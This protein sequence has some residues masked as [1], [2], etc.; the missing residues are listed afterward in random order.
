MSDGCGHAG[1]FAPSG[2]N[3]AS[4]W[5]LV[6][7]QVQ[8]AFND[9]VAKFVL[10]PFGA[11]L[12]AHGAGFRGIEHL[13]AALLVLPFILFAPS[14]GWLADRFAKHAVIR[15]AAWLQ[16]AVL[17][18]MALALWQRQLW[19]AI[20][21][22]FLLALQ[23]AVLS[24][25]KMG[26]VK[27]LLGS[28]RLA[29][30]SGVMEAT[31]ILAILAGQILGG[32]WFDLGLRRGAG[33]GLAD[34]WDAALLTVLGLWAG[35]VLAILLAHAVERTRPQGGGAFS[36][37]LAVAH[38]RDARMVWRDGQLRTSV[39]GVAYFWGFAGFVNLVVLQVAK[40]LHGGGQG[41]GTAV[42]VMMTWASA[43]I[44]AGSVLA[45]LKSR[46]GLDWGL[47]P[48]GAFVMAGGLFV[49]AGVP[50]GSP[51]R[52]W[53]LAVAGA[54]AAVF[55][56]PLNAHVQDHPPAVVR[57]AV[58]A[59]TNLF[60]NL[61]GIAA[62]GLQFGAAVAGVPVR[63]QFAAVGAVTLAVGWVSTW[64]HGADMVRSL[65][66]PVLRWFYRTRVLG[67]ERMP[68]RG[69]VLLLANHVTFADAFLVT[70]VSPRP[71][72]F[73][74]AAE[75]GRNLL[76]RWFTRLFD[77]VQLDGNRPRE[78][79]RLAA[80]AV[81]A[82][83]VVCVFP[84][85]QLSR[86]G[87]MNELRRGFELI[88]RQADGPVV[89]LHVDGM[90]G[91][92]FSFAG[93]G[94][95]AARPRRPRWPVVAAFAPPLEPGQ[96]TL[97]AVRQAL[98]AAAADCLAARVAGDE[99]SQKPLGGGGGAA[100]GDARRRWWANGFQI[101]WTAAL[102]PGEG[103]C[104]WADDAEVAG[105]RGLVEAFPASFGAPVQLLDPGELPAAGGR[106]VG[107]AVAR[108]RL[109]AATAPVLLLD[110]SAGGPPL[111]GVVEHLPCLAVEGVVVA[112]SMPDPPL[113]F[114]TSPRQHGVRTG[115]RGRLLSGFVL[116]TGADGQ[117]LL[118]GPA[119]PP[120]GLRLPAGATIDH[121]GFVR[122]AARDA[123][124]A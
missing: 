100:D 6:G 113:P 23:S 79:I 45:A 82:G 38:F 91:S 103:F 9:N 120:A 21:A 51:V 55:L 122:L 15:F 61:A 106:V 56:V 76:V 92:F 35:A 53:M 101:G 20:L 66:V 60:C 75:F 80:A 77:T 89:A 27:E 7:M 47:V 102:P 36:W 64:R 67:A 81:A 119:C 117:P 50:A 11:W 8:N 118:R 30:A 112:L 115:C 73:V 62:V 2:R 94:F 24:P 17:G 123:G 18:L 10:L 33:A 87:I 95:F 49:L 41:T 85:G 37:A 48:I 12:V 83:D 40:Q 69:G 42:S 96:A 71:V 124:L 114:D 72:R 44:A 109:A 58:L 4:F 19:L 107:G 74:M 111:P 22:F 110:F 84:E 90:W 16:L 39:L 5:G 31:V 14:C 57:G 121:A 108:G 104:R 3:W 29:F 34:G 26:V 99:W 116:A 93:G 59:V 43:G 25:A 54:G 13:L 70:A 28:R 46:R 97:A 78:A 1:E 86:T 105:L 88:A 98:Q 63:W 65:G 32:L 52:D 68:E